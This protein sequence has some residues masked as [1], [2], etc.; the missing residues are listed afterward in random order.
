MDDFTDYEALRDQGAAPDAV[1]EEAKA[2]GLDFISSILMLRSVY[3][4]DVA[5]AK[6]IIRRVDEK[7]VT[8]LECDEPSV[9]I[10][11]IVLEKI[12]HEDRQRKRATLLEGVAIV[13]FILGGLF[14]LLTVL[15]A[16]I[17]LI[18]VPWSS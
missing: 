16:I 15:P 2:N 1:Y 6:A 8:P 18:M 7:E 13:G 9:P 17:Y 14:F 4:L 12:K 10:V 3:N 11:E 5:G